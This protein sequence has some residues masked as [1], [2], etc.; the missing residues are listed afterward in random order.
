MQNERKANFGID[1]SK[2]VLYHDINLTAMQHAKAHARIQIFSA[3]Q[4]IAPKSVYQQT[5]KTDDPSNITAMNRNS[6]VTQNRSAGGLV[7]FYGV[8]VNGTCRESFSQAFERTARKT[9]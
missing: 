2:W 9:G 1:F 6:V 8:P 4:K 3:I 5:A 7:V